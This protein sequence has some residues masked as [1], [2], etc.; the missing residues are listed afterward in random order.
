MS[1]AQDLILFD[2]DC[3]YCNGWVRWIGRRDTRR[4]FRSVPLTSDEGLALRTRYNVPDAVDS[5]VLVKDGRAYLRS[6]AAWRVLAALPGWGLV[7]TLLRL[8]PRFLRNWGY[9][10]VAKNRHR[11]GMDDSCDLPS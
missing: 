10:L 7:A 4:R 9:N 8:V 3:A 1:T 2:G 5:I 6:D 11:L